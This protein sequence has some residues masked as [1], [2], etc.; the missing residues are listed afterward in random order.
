MVPPSMMT[1]QRVAAMR[2]PSLGKADPKGLEAFFHVY[3]VIDSNAF[4][5]TVKVDGKAIKSQLC[6]DKAAILKFL[7]EV[8]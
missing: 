4:G 8:L 7:E 2:R 3:P 6:A 1:A 5:V